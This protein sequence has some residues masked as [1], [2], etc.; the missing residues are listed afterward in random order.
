V[1]LDAGADPGKAGAEL[2]FLDPPECSIDRFRFACAVRYL[3]K[4]IR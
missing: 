4:C 1:P 3:G 2:T